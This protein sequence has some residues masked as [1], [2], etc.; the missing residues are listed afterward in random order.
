[1]KTNGFA[2]ISGTISGK[3]GVTCLPRGDAP[4]CQQSV[5]NYTQYDIISY[6][7]AAAGTTVVGVTVNATNK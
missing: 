3:S 7:S 2:S 5:N 4:D 1:V 6:R